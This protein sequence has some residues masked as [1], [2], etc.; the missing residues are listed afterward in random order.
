MM[1]KIEKYNA[2]NTPLIIQL[3]IILIQYWFEVDPNHTEEIKKRILDKIA[4]N[5]IPT[6][7]LLEKLLERETIRK[8]FKGNTIHEDTCKKLMKIKTS[9]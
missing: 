1:N 6:K 3:M 2:L 4:S 9:F 5:K 8:L 7:K